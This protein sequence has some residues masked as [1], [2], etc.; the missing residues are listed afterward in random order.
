MVLAV[1]FGAFAVFYGADRL[2]AWQQR[3]SFERRRSTADE[4]ITANGP[5]GRLII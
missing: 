2:R 4:P 1:L 3:H 5:T